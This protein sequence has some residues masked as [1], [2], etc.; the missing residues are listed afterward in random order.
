MKMRQIAVAAVFLICLSVIADGKE[1]SAIKKTG[2]LTKRS[3][4][5]LEIGSKTCMPCKMMQPVMKAIEDKYKGEVAVVF[6]D[7]SG[8]MGAMAAEKYGVRMIPTQVF[9]DAEGNEFFR[10]T[11]FYPSKEISKIIDKEL[12][13][14]A[15][16]V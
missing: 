9:L 14:Y 8:N 15:G 10:H 2:S 4:T 1:I 7:V 13:R 12:G 5:F 11:G 16:D 3:I 6:Y